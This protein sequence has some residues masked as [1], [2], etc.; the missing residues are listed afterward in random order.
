VDRITPVTTAEDRSL[1]AHAR[2]F[3]DASPVPTEPFAEWVISGRFPAGRP[4]WEGAG[5][6]LV[7]DIT[8]YEQH[9]LWLLNASHSLLAS[10]GSIRGHATI[11]GAIADPQCRS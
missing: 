11:D 10:A 2:G 6:Q 8:P 3:E 5:A 4:A 1:V 7:E 9:K